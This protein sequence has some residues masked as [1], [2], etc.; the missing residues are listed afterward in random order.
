METI[1]TLKIQ[2]RRFKNVIPESTNAL[3]ELG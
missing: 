3:T 2:A 1:K